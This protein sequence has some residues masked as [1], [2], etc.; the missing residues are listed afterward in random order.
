MKKT[1]KNNIDDLI[2]EL[3][4]IKD[5]YGNVDAELTIEVSE[6]KEQEQEP[7]IHI[8]VRMLICRGTFGDYCQEAGLNPYCLNEG[9][10]TENERVSLTKEQYERFIG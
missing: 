1:F 7:S 4:Q 2:E 8:P 6:E 10:M 5:Q 3:N 9:L